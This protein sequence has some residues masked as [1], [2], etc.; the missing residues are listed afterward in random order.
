[1][2]SASFLGSCLLA[3]AFWFYGSASAL[4]QTPTPTPT[5]GSTA[6]TAVTGTC[7]VLDNTCAA[8]DTTFVPTSVKVSVT[9][10]ITTATCLGTTTALPAK[11]TKCNG[12]TLGGASGETAP[13]QPCTILLG[14]TS[15]AIDD[16]TETI[17]KTGKVTLTCKSG[18]TDKK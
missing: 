4:A 9:K 17:T 18:G 14:T 12:E 10:T 15:A 6:E 8:S 1:M 7:A 2:K 11:T 3:G 16:W 5:P 13:L